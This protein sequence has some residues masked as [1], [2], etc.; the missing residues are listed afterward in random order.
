MEKGEEGAANAAEALIRVGEDVG[1]GK[2][3]VR[4]IGALK[5]IKLAV[6]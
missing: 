3:L 4:R 5:G 6:G 2:E 1:A